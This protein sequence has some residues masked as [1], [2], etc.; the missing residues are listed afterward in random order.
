MIQTKDVLHPTW[1]PILHKLYEEPLL[2]LKD[3]ILPNISYYPEKQNIFRVFKMPVEQVKVVILG[4]DPY[5][6]KGDA[7]GLSFVNG[8]PKVPASLRI[9]IKELENQGYDF[10]QIHE[11][12]KQGV[13]LLNTALT[14]EAGNAGSHLDY[15][16][17]FTEEVIKYLSATNPCIW[18][19]WGKKAQ[20]YKR[21]ISKPYMFT[22]EVLKQVEHLPV[23]SQYNFV[24]ESAHPAAEIYSGGNAGFYG[25][26]HFVSVNAI[27]NKKKQK[28]ILW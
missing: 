18:L 22:D 15:W 11:W 17:P 1:S 16:K 28:Q 23:D 24:L 20:E 8:T 21:F 7:I 25:N 10:P 26:N 27:L 19:L 13:F 14:V 2:T 4:Q 5:P 6:S 3:N 12:E 9:I